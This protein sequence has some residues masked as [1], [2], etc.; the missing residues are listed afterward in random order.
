MSWLDVTVITA[1]PVGGG[2]MQLVTGVCVGLACLL[3]C[4]IA[5][6]CLVKY[7]ETLSLSNEHFRW[8]KM[9]VAVDAP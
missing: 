8:H 3:S 2:N 1:E 6:I 7:H 4:F 5:T 9:S